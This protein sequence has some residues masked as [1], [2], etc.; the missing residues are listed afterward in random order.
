MLIRSVG[1][2][3]VF[4]GAHA[5]GEGFVTR[6]QLREGPYTRV[7]HGVYADPSMPRD[8][9][10]RCRAAALLMPRQAA[11]GG[12]SSAALLGAPGPGFGDRVTVVLPPD[13]R[14]KGPQGVRVH[15]A[16]VT[17]ADLVKSEDYGRHTV[18]SRT[19]WDVA[20]LERL[21]TSVGV[22]DAMVRAEILDMA[23]LRGLAQ[24]GAGRW[25]SRKVAAATELVDPRSESPPESWVRVACA[26]AGLPAPVPQFDVVDA[27]VWL[28]RVDLAWPEQKLIVEYEGAYHFDGVQIARDDVRIARL[29]AAGWTVI[30]LTAHDLRDMDGVVRRIAD[31]LRD[32]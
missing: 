13:V 1:L 12:W 7:L 2:H 21:S 26:L 17:A 4:I 32:S 10:L 28:G 3:G 24:Q 29:V 6:R 27:G 5:V 11:I 16:P 15:R 14:W 9:L 22:L 31:A 25:G 18:A 19:A 20:A 23:A 8:H 30:R